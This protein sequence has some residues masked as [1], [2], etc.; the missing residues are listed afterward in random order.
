MILRRGTR[1]LTELTFQVAIRTDP[2]TS[3]SVV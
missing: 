2:V 3:R 1:C